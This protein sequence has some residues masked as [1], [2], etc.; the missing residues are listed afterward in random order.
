MV[1]LDPTALSHR[2][3]NGYFNKFPHNLQNMQADAADAF[4]KVGA[5]TAYTFRDKK[6]V[7]IMYLQKEVE[8]FKKYATGWEILHSRIPFGDG[9]GSVDPVVD[10]N[11]TVVGHYGEFNSR[12]IFV[13]GNI[14]PGEVNAIEEPVRKVRWP[15][16]RAVKNNNGGY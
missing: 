4:R 12:D 8:K 11:M 10:E 9:S 14:H 3:L 15:G 7:P 13:S 1:A 6:L 5:R 16:W 2:T